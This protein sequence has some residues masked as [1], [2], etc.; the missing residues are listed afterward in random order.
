[1]VSIH[2][3]LGSQGA[4]LVI[5]DRTGAP[6][7]EAAKTL[8]EKRNVELKIA[9]IVETREGAK[10]GEHIHVNLSWKKVK[11]IQSGG[12]VLVRSDGNGCLAFDGIG[13]CGID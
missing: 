10:E 12:A 8:M 6:L 11:E 7:V 3:L 2:D 1:L 4:L 5:A 9:M 13:G